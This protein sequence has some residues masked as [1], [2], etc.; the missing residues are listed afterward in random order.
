MSSLDYSFVASIGDDADDGMWCCHKCGALV[1][2]FMR[3]THDIFH[4]RLE[5]FE[6]EQWREALS[7]E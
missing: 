5:Q 7:D 1:T 3:G 4:T 2:R 6:A